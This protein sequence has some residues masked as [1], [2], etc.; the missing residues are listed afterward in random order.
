MCFTQCLPATCHPVATSHPLGPPP[1]PPAP[2]HRR[3]EALEQEQARLK[4]IVARFRL[5]P[6]YDCPNLA[7]VPSASSL[8]II[9]VYP[10]PSVVEKLLCSLLRPPVSSAWIQKGLVR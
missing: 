3:L 8:E 5:R 2:T 6:P 7:S 4:E 9:R 1:F 10:R